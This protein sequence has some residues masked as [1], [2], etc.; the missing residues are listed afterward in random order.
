M[1][2]DPPHCM[3]PLPSVSGLPKGDPSLNYLKLP[4]LSR[5]ARASIAGCSYLV[6]KNPLKHL[7]QV[8]TG[9]IT[10]PFHPCLSEL[11]LN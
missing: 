3:P 5:C 6:T 4:K 9:I 1:I 7:R 8:P 10:H 2:D 11:P